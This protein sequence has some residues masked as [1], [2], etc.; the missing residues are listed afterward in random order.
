MVPS[1]VLAV[2][3]DCEHLTCDGFSL[4][5]TVHS[6]SHEF[7]AECF[8]GLSLSPRRDNSGT[9]FVGSTHSGPLLYRQLVEIHIIATTQLAE[10]A[11]WCWSNPTP[12][13]AYVG[14]SLRGPAAVPFATK[15]V[16]PP[17]IDFSPEASLWQQGQCIKPQAHR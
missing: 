9:T 7:I 16:P 17:S 2:S 12:N 13:M 10:C 14:A 11:R 1:S 4:G 6:G 5:E 8:G 3:V 15:M